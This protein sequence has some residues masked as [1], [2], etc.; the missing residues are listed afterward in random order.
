MSQDEPTRRYNPQVWHYLNRFMVFIILLV[1][2]AF[3]VFTFYPA[4]TKRDELGA[5]LEAE[6][7][8]L[9]AEQ[10][11]QKQRSR[12][13]TLLQTDPEYV[14]IIARDKLGVMKPGETIY[15]LDGAKPAAPAVQKATPPPAG[16]N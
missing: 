14:E 16:K 1:A 12:E 3:G 5:K 13:V 11:L 10:L 4:W 8:K 9:A 15:R 6:Q 2:A 7:S